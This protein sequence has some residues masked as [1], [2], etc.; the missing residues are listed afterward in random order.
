VV[1][2]KSEKG[3]QPGRL[4]SGERGQKKVKVGGEV[5]REGSDR[6]ASS[7]EFGREV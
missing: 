7:R 2:S 4:K 6:I 3:E 5:K 1:E